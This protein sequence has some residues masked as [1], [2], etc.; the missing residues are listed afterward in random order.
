MRSLSALLDSNGLGK[1][2][3]QRI[4]TKLGLFAYTGGVEMGEDLHRL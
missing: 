2:V 3:E 1:H 4:S